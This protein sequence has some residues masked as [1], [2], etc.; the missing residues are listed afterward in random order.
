[1][2]S[3]WRF[4]F[5]ISTLVVHLALGA[6]VVKLVYPLVSRESRMALRARWCRR[7]LRVL[8]VELRIFGTVP[9][10]CHLIAANHI[11]WLDVFAIGAVFPCWFV[12]KDDTRSWP[13]VGWIAA[14]NDTLFLRRA[15]A[16]A[17]YRMNAQIRARLAVRQPV[18]IFPEG[19]TTDGGRVLD[20]YPALFQPAVDTAYPVL[21]LAIR[22][23]DQTGR[24]AAG[25]AYINEDPLWKSLRAVLDARRTEAHLLLSDTFDPPGWDRRSLAANVCR[26]ITLARSPLAGAKV[27]AERGHERFPPRR[28]LLHAAAEHPPS[29]TTPD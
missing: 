29:A 8:G 19:T 11:S 21:P 16:R 1:V 13:L 22:Y 12:S 25:V 24:L 10:G 6:A 28:Q 15:S 18:V 26:A 7:V 9:A 3:G 14:A 5:R 23:R 4:V 17:A 20:F 2:T 27:L